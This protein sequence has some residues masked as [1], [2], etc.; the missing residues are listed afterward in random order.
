M[1]CTSPPSYEERFVPVE[2]TL[3]NREWT[4]DWILFYYYHPPFVYGIT[5]KIGPVQGGTEVTISGS[6]FEETGYVMCKFGNIYVK[7]I[8]VSQN[9]LKCNSPQVEKPGYVTLQVAIRADEFSSWTN[10]KYLYYDTPII[11]RIEPMCGPESW[12]T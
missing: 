6:N 8:Y 11:D 1:I 10:T 12:F 3:N 9:E 2:I 4:R 5:P 7:G